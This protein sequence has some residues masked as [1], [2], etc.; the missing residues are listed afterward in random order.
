MLPRPK[1]PTVPEWNQI[2]K[3]KFEKDVVGFYITGHPLDEFKLELEGFC[4]CSLDK[5]Y[6]IKSPEIK[7]A[8]IVTSLQTKIAKNGNPFC[9]FKIEDYSTAIEMALFGDDYVRMGQ[10]VDVGRFLHIT[11][12]TQNRWNSEQLEFKATNIRLLNEMREKFCKEV[13]V[14]LMLDSLNSQLISQINELINAHPGT[15][16]LSLNVVDPIE[17]IE[18]SLQ[19][20][21]V[22]VF[23][24]NA[25]L[26]ALEAMDG[27]TCKVA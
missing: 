15:C 23:P 7:V 20:R 14:S 11:G 25:F 19:A 21:T 26:R 13:R 8:G 4:N 1:P 17:R 6:E 18:V 12:K 9:I 24:D 3:L 10:Y 2:E 27:V 16:S 5:I 22:K